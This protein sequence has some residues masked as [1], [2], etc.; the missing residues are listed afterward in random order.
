MT[1]DE[2][3]GFRLDAIDLEDKQAYPGRFTLDFDVTEFQELC[4][5][6][7]VGKQFEIAV[8]ETQ[9]YGLEL[10][11]CASGLCPGIKE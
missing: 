6:A 5:L 1:L 2:I 7:T 10:G 4:R 11:A 8:R 9:E 3:H